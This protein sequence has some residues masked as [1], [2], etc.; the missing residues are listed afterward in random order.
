LPTVRAARTS[1]SGG[2]K[3]DDCGGRKAVNAGIS[4]WQQRARVETQ[5]ICSLSKAAVRALNESSCHTR[6]L[7]PGITTSFASG[8]QHRC[9]CLIRRDANGQIRQSRASRAEPLPYPFA[10]NFQPSAEQPARNR[11]AVED[12]LVQRRGDLTA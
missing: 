6:F 3:F 7:N 10:I 5:R 1:V 11:T 8:W 2:G 9:G 12:Q 4:R